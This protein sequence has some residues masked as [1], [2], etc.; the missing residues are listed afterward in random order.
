[1]VTETIPNNKD[2]FNILT[3]YNEYKHI[4]NGI[5]KPMRC[6][7]IFH[8]LKEKR[9]IDDVNDVIVAP[10]IKIIM[11]Q[12]IRSNNM[13]EFFKKRNSIFLRIFLLIT[14]IMTICVTIPF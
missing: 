14:F 12:K 3:L 8:I 7:L 5:A 1:M 11:E 10:R 6:M 2:D 4:M 13:L 9:K